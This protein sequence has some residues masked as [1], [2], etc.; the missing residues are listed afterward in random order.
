MTSIQP[1]TSLFHVLSG[2]TKLVNQ[3]RYCYLARLSQIQAAM[4]KDRELPKQRASR[5][6]PSGTTVRSANVAVPR[7]ERSQRQ[8]RKRQRTP[9]DWQQFRANAASSL[10]N[11]T[12]ALITDWRFF[13]LVGLSLTGGLTAFSIAFLFKLPVLPN[14]PS[15]FWPLASGSMRLHCAQLAAGKETVNDLLEA[16]QLMNTLKSD[17]PLYPEASRLIEQ[18]STEILDLTE[19]EFQAGKLKEAI[20]GARK[21]PAN[22]AAAKLVEEKIKTWEKVWTE[23]EKIYRKV[24]ELLKKSQVADAQLFAAKLLSIDNQYWQTTKNSAP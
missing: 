5:R 7:S 13:T 17:H 24:G 12:F 8:R 16:I 3:Q 6:A 20:A 2:V 19:K 23:A 9:I 14:C 22:A 18:W 1:Q 15:V 4:T 21:I 10:K 11:K